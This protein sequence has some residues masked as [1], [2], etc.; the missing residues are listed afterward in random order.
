VAIGDRAAD[1]ADL[2]R[3][4]ASHGIAAWTRYGMWKKLGELW[5]MIPES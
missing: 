2:R 1:G 4:S 3:A 5:H